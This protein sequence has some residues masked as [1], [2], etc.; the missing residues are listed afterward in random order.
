MSDMIETKEDWLALEK[1][2]NPN[3]TEEELLREYGDDD[4]GPMEQPDPRTGWPRL[5][6]GVDN[7][8]FPGSIYDAHP[9]LKRPPRSRKLEDDK[10]TARTGTQGP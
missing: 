2:L 7:E 10:H 5:P 9:E 8:S 1:E 6:T 4:D 3:A